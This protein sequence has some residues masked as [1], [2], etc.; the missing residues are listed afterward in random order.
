M[1][2]VCPSIDEGNYQLLTKRSSEVIEA[3]SVATVEHAD[4]EWMDTELIKKPLNLKSL[5]KLGSPELVR[6][7]LEYNWSNKYVYSVIKTSFHNPNLNEEWYDGSKNPPKTPAQFH[8]NGGWAD[9]NIKME[10][11]AIIHDYSEGLG[12]PVVIIFYLR[13]ADRKEGDVY[14]KNWE[15]GNWVRRN[16]RSIH[17]YESHC[18]C[19]ATCVEG[20]K[21]SCCSKAA[22]VKDENLYKCRSAKWVSK[23]AMQTNSQLKLDDGSGTLL[24]QE[25][26]AGGKCY[27]F[28]TGGRS[29]VNE[30]YGIKD[31]CLTKEVR[32]YGTYHAVEAVENKFTQAGCDYYDDGQDPTPYFEVKRWNGQNKKY[33]TGNVTMNGKCLGRD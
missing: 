21:Y 3:I 15:W 5:L 1:T 14:G 33:E 10:G 7:E 24:I 31:K 18:I 6:K 4:N 8:Y 25:E 13:V 16:D 27:S 2:A 23:L 22:L 17:C 30:F 29:S 26:S 11:A 32:T 20:V 19:C 12:S 28:L 9:G